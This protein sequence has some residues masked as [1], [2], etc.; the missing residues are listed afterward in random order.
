MIPKVKTWQVKFWT[1]QDSRWRGR[2]LKARVQTINK[3][4][5]K[6][7]ANEI[8][9]YPAIFSDRVTVGLIN[10]SNSWYNV[11]RGEGN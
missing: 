1:T 4:F 7:M 11:P 2:V 10:K 9:G 3:R 6:M 5:A 8:L